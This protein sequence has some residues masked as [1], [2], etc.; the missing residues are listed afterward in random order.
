MA[1]RSTFATSPRSRLVSMPYAMNAG[2]RLEACN[3]FV[4]LGRN[5]RHRRHDLVAIERGETEDAFHE[6]CEATGLL[7]DNAE[8]SFA[9]LLAGDLPES[10]QLGEHP[11]LCQRGASSCDTPDTNSLRSLTSSCCRPSW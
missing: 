6:E 9:A 5:I 4:D 3:N 8:R 7:V 2:E 10:Q 1:A 11:D